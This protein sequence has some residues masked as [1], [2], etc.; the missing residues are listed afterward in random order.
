MPHNAYILTTPKAH[1]TIEVQDLNDK[2]RAEA[3]T[4]LIQRTLDA[5]ELAPHVGTARGSIRVSPLPKAT[6]AETPQPPPTP[7]PKPKSTSSRGPR[8]PK[9]PISRKKKAAAK[10]KSKPKGSRKR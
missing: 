8:L 2:Q 7:S 6:D 9:G 1:I 3:M 10:P 5:I 4:H